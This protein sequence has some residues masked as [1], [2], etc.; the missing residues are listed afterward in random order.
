MIVF[1]QNVAPVVSNLYLGLL[2]DSAVFTFLNASVT[3]TFLKQN[4][5]HV[6]F[7]FLSFFKRDVVFSLL[8]FLVSVLKFPH[9]VHLNIFI[10]SLDFCDATAY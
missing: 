8:K 4:L 6:L 3:V 1:S 2:H 10:F 5:L 7:L 9:Y